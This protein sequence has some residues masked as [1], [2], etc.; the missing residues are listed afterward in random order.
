VGGN[1]RQFALEKLSFVNPSV[2][3]SLDITIIAP[4]YFWVSP[5]N[6]RQSFAQWAWMCKWVMNLNALNGRTMLHVFAH[7]RMRTAENSG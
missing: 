7:Q 4:I 3:I 5:P 6:C 2:S 1:E